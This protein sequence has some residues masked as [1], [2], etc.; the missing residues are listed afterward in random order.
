MAGRPH[1]EMRCV[2]CNRPVDLQTD[3]STNE[4]GKAVHEDCYARSISEGNSSA[5]LDEDAD[6]LVRVKRGANASLCDRHSASVY[7]TALRVWGDSAKAEEVP[8]NTF[9]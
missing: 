8:Q 2:L 3:L 1:V 6:L 9:M 4:N 7:S 5:D